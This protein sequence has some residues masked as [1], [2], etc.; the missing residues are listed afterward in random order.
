M[1]SKSPQ[2]A[3]LL[4]SGPIGGLPRAFRLPIE[5][6]SLPAS[7]KSRCKICVVSEEIQL[8]PRI[9]TPPERPERNWLPVGLAAAI[10]LALVG[11]FFVF[12]GHSQ[13]SA[14]PPAVDSPLDPYAASLELSQI[15]MSESANLAGGKVTYLDGVIANRGP[16]TVSAVSVQVLFHSYTHGIAQNEPMALNLIRTRDPYIDTEPLSA[17]PLAPGAHAEFRL[18]F[19]QV[20]PDW[21][22]AYPEVRIL[23]VGSK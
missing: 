13:T 20:S 19:D 18:I 12:G 15:A 16:R 23:R 10:I 4:R 21:D 8:E 5:N 2:S 3:C 22:G 7:P 6:F 17:A 1:L 11:A 9:G 14:T